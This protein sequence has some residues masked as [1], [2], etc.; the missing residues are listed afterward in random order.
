M[1]TTATLSFVLK[2]F[3]IKQERYYSKI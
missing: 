1:K 2:A 3:V